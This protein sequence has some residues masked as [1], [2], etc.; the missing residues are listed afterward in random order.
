MNC[1][2]KKKIVLADE[3]VK[4]EKKEINSQPIK[5]EYF[6]D[7]AA[8][9]MYELLLRVLFVKHSYSCIKLL[10]GKGN[11]GGDAYTLGAILLERGF[12]V[13]AYQ[14]FPTINELSNRK[15]QYFYHKGGEI[16]YVEDVSHF[17]VRENDLIIDG[18]FGTG[19]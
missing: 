5:S 16:V 4:C 3:M 15:S 11:N 8:F 19:F 12:C 18:I 7:N 10:I 14:L 17:P 9:G 13:I 2:P 1:F 6:M